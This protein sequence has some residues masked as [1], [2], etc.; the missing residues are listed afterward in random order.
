MF[1]FIKKAFA[2]KQSNPAPAVKKAKK[3]VAKK[4]VA[5]KKVS[6]NHPRG[7]W[8][9]ERCKADA[10]KYEVKHRWRFQSPKAFGIAKHFG[11]LD[12]CTAHM[13]PGRKPD[14]YWTLARCKAEAKK[15]KSRTELKRNCATAYTT[16]SVRGW[17]DQCY[18]HMKT[19]VKT[20]K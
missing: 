14:G 17:S 10:L 13:K 20:K 6:K 5:K 15:Y 1:D 8:T 2:K 9:L 3:K 7:Y 11:W 16:I 4:K 12:E 19:T 18:R